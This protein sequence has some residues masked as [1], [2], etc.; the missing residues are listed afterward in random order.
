M[1]KFL[2][3]SGHEIGYHSEIIDQSVIWNEDIKENLLRDIEVINRIF[4]IDIKGIASHGGMTG[5][6][7]LD[8][9]K[10]N[11]ASD[12]GLLYEAYDWFDKAFY[13]S[14]SEWTQWKA[15]NNGKLLEG[16]RRTF[17]EH[18]EQENHELIYLLI[19]PD[20]YYDRHFYE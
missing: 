11:T 8:F 2:I 15:Y 18:I 20:T 6:N 9:W 12:F 10:N 17:K 1:I 7:N 14:D 19:H 13:I 4:N 5:L 16:D 3:E